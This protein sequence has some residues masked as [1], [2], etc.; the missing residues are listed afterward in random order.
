MAPPAKKFKWKPSSERPRGL[1]SSAVLSSQLPLQLEDDVPDFPRGRRNSMSRVERNDANEGGDKDFDTDNRVLKKRKRA[2]RVQNQNNSTEDDLGLLF[3]DGITGKL[4]RFANKITLKNVSSGMKLWVV[5]A[6]VTEKDIVVS[7]PGGL[8]GLVRAGDAFDPIPGDEVKGYAENSFLSRIYHKGQ[9]VSCVVLQVD[10][11]RKELA[12]RKIWLS[13]RL[14][15][16]HKS[17]TL[18]AVQEGMV[19]SAYV[20]TTGDHGFMLHFG[21]PSFA[22]FMPKQNHSE[23]IGQLIQGIVKS[24]DRSKKIVHMSSDLDVISKY[25]TKELKGISIDLL[26]P[27][28]MFN[29]RILFIDPSTR[30]VG[31]TLSPQLVRNKAPASLVKIADIFEQCKVVRIDKGSGLLL[32]VPTVP[33]PTP[34]Y[35]N[36]TDI[37]DKEVKLDKS[38]KEGSSV[39]VRIHGYRHLEGIATGTLKTSAFECQFFTHSDVKPRVV[40]KAKVIAVDSFGAIVQ[41][42]RGVK[43]LCPLRHMSEFEIAKP[44]KKFKVGIDLVFR[45]LGCKSKRITVTH[46]KTLVNS[47]LEILSCYADATDGIVTHGWISKIKKHGCFVRFY[48]GVQGFTPRSEL[49]LGPGIDIQS[50]YHVEQVVKCRVV[51]CIPASRRIK[52]SFNITLTRGSV[53]ELIKAGTLVSG[54]VESISTQTIVVTVHDSSHTKGTISLGHLADHHGLASWLMSVMKPG[55]HFDKL[56][57]L[58]VERNN[59]VLTANYSLVNSTHQQLPVDI[60]QISCH[61]VVHARYKERPT[62]QRRKK[63]QAKK[64]AQSQDSTS[65][66]SSQSQSANPSHPTP[67][68]GPTSSSVPQPQSQP[69]PLPETEPEIWLI[70]LQWGPSRGMQQHFLGIHAAIPRSDHEKKVQL[71]K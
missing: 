25:V 29:A 65:Q 10:D 30:A 66:P 60:S 37:A 35:V 57:D 23:S 71:E 3:G 54:V 39:R 5:I 16:L 18:D 11:D 28:M 56:L 15:L 13:L 44:Q 50:T 21:L 2:K 19:L 61:S 58:D 62:R 59:L 17:L 7:L 8:R 41:I 53:D 42:A 70:L 14:S 69:P 27:G 55:H 38:F 6:E 43:A 48:N 20:K 32:E 52:L 22:G 47:K 40:V 24:V 1:P 31:L 49:G 33:V 34:T 68:S 64:E 4:P 36:V 51:N 46:K 45:I 26:V 63:Q 12:K 67:P 9:L